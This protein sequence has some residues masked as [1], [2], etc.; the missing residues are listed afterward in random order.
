MMSRMRLA[1]Q[2]ARQNQKQKILDN[3]RYPVKNVGSSAKVFNLA[4][5]RGACAVKM[6]LSMGKIAEGKLA[7]VAV[8]GATSP[9][10][11]C[12]A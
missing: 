2:L 3:D 9:T 7:D 11:D 6:K 12:A 4:T 1:L 5:I 10:M 8:F